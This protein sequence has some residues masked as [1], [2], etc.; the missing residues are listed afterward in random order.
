M[1]FFCDVGRGCSIQ[2]FMIHEIGIAIHIAPDWQI[3]CHKLCLGFVGWY[4]EKLGCPGM[5]VEIDKAKIGKKNITE[6]IS[7]KGSGC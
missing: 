4:S 7:L 3:V 2:E 5:I 6:D 1:W